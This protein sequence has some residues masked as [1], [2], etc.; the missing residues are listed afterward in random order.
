MQQVLIAG[1]WRDANSN[2]SFQASNPATREPLAN[3]YPVSTWE[4][5][6]AALTSAAEAAVG[7]R[8]IAGAQIAEF[9]EAYAT[10]I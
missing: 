3:E 9:L 2:E 6:D 7:L 10:D 4:D 5:C 1:Q 8:S